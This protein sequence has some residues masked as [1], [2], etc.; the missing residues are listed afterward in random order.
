MQKLLKVLASLIAALLLSTATAQVDTTDPAEEEPAFK[1]VR[2]KSVAPVYPRKALLDGR[3][4]WVDL[5]LTVSPD[6]KVEDVVVIAAE[7][8]RLFERA[9]IRAAKKWQFA[10]PAD[11]GLTTS[12]TGKI[13]I[14][15]NLDS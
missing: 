13:R 15:F 3:E 6:G 1:L 8:K 14:S 4:G 12:Q 9:A 7:P 2:T 11:S 5:L 10:P